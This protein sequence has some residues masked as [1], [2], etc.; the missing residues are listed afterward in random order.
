MTGT[1]G[2]VTGRR[3]A[4]GTRRLSLRARLLAATV[5]VALGGLLIA[6]VATYVALR[7]F[8]VGRIDASLEA[9]AVPLGR[10][11]VTRDA[12]GPDATAADARLAAAAPGAYVELRDPFGRVR[13]SGSTRGRYAPGT[14][15]L[16]GSVD[17]RP[18]ATFTT[19]GREPGAP[20]F[21]VRAQQLGGGGTLLVAL[22]L[23]E[24][25]RTLARLVVIEVVV[26]L[27]ALGAVVVAGLTLVRIGLRPLAGIETTAATIAAGDLSARVDEDDRTEV[28]RLGASLNRMLAQIETA[29]AERAATEDRLRRFVADASHELRTPLAAV[30]AYAELF[31]RGARHRPEDLTRILS[32][33]RVETERMRR[34]VEDL[35]ALARLDEGRPPGDEPVELCDLAREAVEAARVVGP[36][37]PV[38]LVAGGPV[39][40]RGDRLALR[41]VLDNLLANVRCHTPPGTQATVEVGRSEAGGARVRVRDDGPGIPADHRERVFERFHRVEGSRARS[42]GGGT[43]LGLAV[44]A[45]IAAAHGGTARADAAPGGGTVVTVELPAPAAPVPAQPVPDRPGVAGLTANRPDG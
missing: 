6:D 1:T 12:W 36:A 32:G 23:D 3:P 20:P 15:A 8:L 5:T 19:P 42:R 43:G 28:G 45:A 25:E 18:V 17:P 40:V 33:I 11:L 16:P 35:L 31:E 38:L 24:V 27:A 41:Q 44:V 34:L 2:E 39:W 10:L 14:P 30:A 13:L 9:A 7:S 4:V 22:P 37:W 21:R 29:F 26:T